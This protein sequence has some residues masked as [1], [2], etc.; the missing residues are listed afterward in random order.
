MDS[1]LPTL[2]L[3]PHSVAMLSVL[4]FPAL[5]ASFQTQ[6]HDVLRITTVEERSIVLC[7]GEDEEHATTVGD[8]SLTACLSDGDEVVVDDLDSGSVS[9]R[10]DAGRVVFE[11]DLDVW[12]Q[13]TGAPRS[14]IRATNGRGVA[15]PASTTV[16][17]GSAC[18]R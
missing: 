4:P 15:G 9:G 17:S 3:T 10:I 12:V 6:T 5:L 18:D 8:K 2:S 13:P 14:R 16:P 11:G 7:T 1:L